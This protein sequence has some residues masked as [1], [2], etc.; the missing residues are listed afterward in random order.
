MQTLHALWLGRCMLREKNTR[1]GRS[2]LGFKFISAASLFES[3]TKFFQ[4][5][6]FNHLTVDEMSSASSAASPGV[7]SPEHAA[8]VTPASVVSPS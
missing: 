6:R 4:L 5:D 7:I 8:D 2:A 1:G 3:P